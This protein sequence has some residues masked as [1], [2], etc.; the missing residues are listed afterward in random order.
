MVSVI[1]NTTIM[2]YEI[3]N[4]ITMVYDRKHHPN[5]VK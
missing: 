2:V 1:E 4:T 3:E 5:S